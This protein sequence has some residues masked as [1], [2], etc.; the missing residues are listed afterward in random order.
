MVLLKKFADD[1]LLLVE[2]DAVKEEGERCGRKGSGLF[3][4]FIW[5]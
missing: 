4:S 1:P 2:F 5:G 3:Y